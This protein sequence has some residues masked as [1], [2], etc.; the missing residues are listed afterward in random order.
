MSLIQEERSHY[1]K[2]KLGRLIKAKEKLCQSTWDPEYDIYGN[3]TI[4]ITCIY[5]Y[6]Y[7]II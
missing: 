7:N 1:K 3:P 2:Q 6:L 5:R 4:P